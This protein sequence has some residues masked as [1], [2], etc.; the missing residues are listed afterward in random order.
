MKKIIIFLALIILLV[1]SIW[2]TTY[3]PKIISNNQTSTSTLA[4]EQKNDI[5][6]YILATSTIQ[7]IHYSIKIPKGFTKKIDEGKDSWVGKT[8]TSEA[9]PAS[10]SVYVLNNIKSRDDLIKKEKNIHSYKGEAGYG[11]YSE[12]SQGNWSVDASEYAKYMEREFGFLL[13]ANSENFSEV[14]LPVKIFFAYVQIDD[15]PGK[16]FVFAYSP[17]GT[18]TENKPSMILGEKAIFYDIIENSN[19]YTDK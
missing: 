6:E 2:Y 4:I 7:G 1:L 11:N 18:R 17:D 13:I 19:L 12:M 15:F 5:D 3:T 9:D 16:V 8:I 14:M 10:I